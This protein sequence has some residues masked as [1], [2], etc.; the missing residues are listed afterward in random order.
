MEQEVD[1][2]GL[3]KEQIDYELYE[4]RTIKKASRKIRKSFHMTRPK[5]IKE[6]IQHIKIFAEH[7]LGNGFTLADEKQNLLQNYSA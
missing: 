6:H 3:S 4:Y 2:L 7:N 1:D 5:L